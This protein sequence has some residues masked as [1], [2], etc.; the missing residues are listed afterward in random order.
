LV[1]QRTFSFRDRPILQHLLH[2]SFSWH[3]LLMSEKRNPLILI[4]VLPCILVSI[5]LFCQQMHYLLKHKMLQFVL[6]YLWLLHVS[7]P[8]DHH[9]GAYIGTLLKL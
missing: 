3:S 4:V 7:V 6:K 9:Q 8:L 2:H 1:F 5:K